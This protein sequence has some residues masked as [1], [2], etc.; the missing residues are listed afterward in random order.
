M[1]N[2]AAFEDAVAHALLQPALGVG[3]HFN[4]TLG[5][6]LS[7]HAGLGALTD[8]S[9]AFHTRNH[10]ATLLALGRIR[11]SALEA[12][13][14]AQY[15]RMISAG[16]QPTHIDSHQHIHAFPLCFDVVAS[17]CQREAIPMRVP[18][19]LT[20][21]GL[22]IPITRRLKQWQLTRMLRRNSRTWQDRVQWNSGLGSVFDLALPDQP[23]Q[24]QHYRTLLDAAPAGV[25]ELM[26]HPAHDTD[27]L[28]GLTAI[29]SISE[30]ESQFLQTGLLP[31]LAADH[32]FTLR[33]YRAL[34]NV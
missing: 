3:L 19:V 18:W 1:T 28:T 17:L 11:R 6:P 13:L 32:G 12:E 10:L 7:E 26:V 4:L 20:L 31:A 14:Q 2:T 24:E 34:A 22:Q 8:R 23:L 33:N 30:R 21:A 15:Q 5:R 27:E 16:L 25:F 9:G 29:G